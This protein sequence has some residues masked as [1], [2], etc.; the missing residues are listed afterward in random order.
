M[1][2]ILHDRIL[3]GDQSM[4]VATAEGQEVR[5][6]ARATCEL[7]ER[8]IEM[9]YDDQ[10]LVRIVRADP[11]LFGPPFHVTGVTLSLAAQVDFFQ[12]PATADTPPVRSAV[13]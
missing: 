11:Y 1:L 13:R 10:A 2:T 9:G 8:L 6:P 12:D 7:A 4:D 3:D 5:R